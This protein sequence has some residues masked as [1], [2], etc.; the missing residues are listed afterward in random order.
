METHCCGSGGRWTNCD[1][2]IFLSVGA[3][4]AISRLISS[5]VG[6]GFP[7]SHGCL[8]TSSMEM[9]WCGL[10][11]SMRLMRSRALSDTLAFWKCDQKRSCRGAW[12]SRRPSNSSGVG[13]SSW[14]IRLL[15]V[16]NTWRC[17]PL[18][19]TF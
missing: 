19:N 6:I 1:W 15:R 11:M 17:L 3:R 9:R 14:F 13:V 2:P 16:T 5:L 18:M 7:A 4:S 10:Y 8:K 12:D